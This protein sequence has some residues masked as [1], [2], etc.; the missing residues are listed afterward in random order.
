MIYHLIKYK[1]L[2]KMYSGGNFFETYA[3]KAMT[4]DKPLRKYI[5]IKNHSKINKLKEEKENYV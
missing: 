2:D 1:S 4:S 5:L 3:M